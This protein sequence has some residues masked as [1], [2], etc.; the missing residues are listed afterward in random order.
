MACGCGKKSDLSQWAVVFANGYEKA[1][2]NEE[3]ARIYYEQV[4]MG[5]SIPPSLRAPTP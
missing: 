3:T 4:R 2:P 5:Q 1:F